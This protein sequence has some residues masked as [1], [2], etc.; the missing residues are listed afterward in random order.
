MGQLNPSRRLFETHW[1][2]WCQSSV[3]YTKGTVRMQWAL[4]V[5]V[6]QRVLSERDGIVGNP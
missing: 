2:N 5:S 6:F 3:A 4:P 1:G